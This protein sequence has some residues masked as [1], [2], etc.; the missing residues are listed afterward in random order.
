M[1]SG[2]SP[3]RRICPCQAG[4]GAAGCSMIVGS[5][6]R[7]SPPTTHNLDFSLPVIPPVGM[8]RG[9]G[10]TGRATPR[11]V[12]GHPAILITTEG[13]RSHRPRTNPVTCLRDGGRYLIFGSNLGRPAHPGWYHNLLASP[14][15][16]EHRTMAEALAGLETLLTASGPGGTRRSH[17]RARQGRHRLGGALR[18]RGRA[19][20]PRTA[21]SASCPVETESLA[22]SR[23]SED[24]NH[25]T[26]PL[27]PAGFLQFS[28]VRARQVRSFMTTDQVAAEVSTAGEPVILAT[29]VRG[30]SLLEAITSSEGRVVAA[31]T[32]PEPKGSTKQ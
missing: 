12:P 15:V 20:H 14:R 32:E 13:K 31:C 18:L 30:L 28:L 25:G 10:N 1:R 24:N 3:F 11:H 7:I 27:M 23:T 2:Y 29:L 21:P 17:R 22:Q 4:P 9:N 19:P 5:R 6:R 26:L 8:E 16:T